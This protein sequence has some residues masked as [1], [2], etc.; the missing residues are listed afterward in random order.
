[1]R[2]KFD[3]VKAD[4]ELAASQDALRLEIKSGDQ[5]ELITVLGGKGVTNDPKKLRLAV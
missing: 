4:E 2:G 1:M 3:I 5:T